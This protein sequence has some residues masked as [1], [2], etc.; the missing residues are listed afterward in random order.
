MGRLHRWS[1]YL[2][3][4]RYTVEYIKGALN[5]VADSLSRRS[6]PIEEDKFVD[7]LINE[8]TI[9]PIETCP[10]LNL[11]D[12]SARETCVWEPCP[13]QEDN[14]DEQNYMSDNDQYDHSK[15]PIEWRLFEIANGNPTLWTTKKQALA[16][17][18]FQIHQKTRSN[19]YK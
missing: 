5:P 2:S 14:T 7:K 19:N 11:W 8:E 16:N 3:P 12:T 18:K 9:S 17:V 13:D 1:I 4:F 15:P 10:N 6:Y